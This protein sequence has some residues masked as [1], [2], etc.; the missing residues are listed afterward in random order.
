MREQFG[1]GLRFVVMNSFSTSADTMAF[2]A[3]HHPELAKE[4]GLELI[5]N[6]S[7][8]VDAG[9]MGPA[10]YAVSPDMEWYGA[11]R[12]EGQSL[13]CIAVHCTTLHSTEF[14]H[15]LTHSFIHS[16]VQ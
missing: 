7:P 5:Q 13:Q 15:S 4:E 1:S 6:R 8:K 14:N 12:G 9:T 11:A 16:F 3:Q 10:E 2:L